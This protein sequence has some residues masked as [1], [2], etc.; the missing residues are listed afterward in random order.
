MIV[1]FVAMKSFSWKLRVLNSV[2]FLLGTSLLVFPGC[3]KAPVVPPGSTTPP[4]V[5]TPPTPTPNSPEPSPTTTPSLVILQPT[6]GAV[7]VDPNV[8]VIVQVA[9]LNLVDTT[10]IVNVSGEGHI[11]YYYD[12]AAPTVQG[13]PAVTAPNTYAITISSSYI[14][15]NVPDGVHTFWVE[16]VNNDNTPLNPPVV[17]KVTVSI[18]TG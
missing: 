8:S 5:V 4:E 12:V 17:Q 2:L 18:F 14:W 3:T 13:Q 9:G 1:R 10:G 7:L 6:E 15:A 11:I 16:L